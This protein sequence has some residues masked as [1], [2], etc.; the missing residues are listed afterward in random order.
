M[1]LALV[2]L[3]S[4]FSLSV[5][6]QTEISGRVLDATTRKPV[7]AATITLHPKDSANIL[8]YTMT[9]KEG[10]F[11][12]KRSTMP[13]FVTIT[14]RAMTI[15][16]QSKTVKSSVGFVEF[17]VKETVTELKEVIVKA[18]KIRQL[19]DTIH[20]DVS[21]FLDETDKSIGDVL[22]KLPGVQVLS[23]GQILY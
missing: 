10:T 11:S 12:L 2:I 3:L 15:E 6:P 18:P 14:V 4:L 16:T 23:S 1:K 17:L 21:S 13:D 7:D 19:G 5:F 9:G 20:Y 22:K 8:S